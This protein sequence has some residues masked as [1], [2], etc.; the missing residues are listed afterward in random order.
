[1]GKISSIIMVLSILAVSSFSMP[2]SGI[3][4]GSPIGVSRSVDTESYIDINN[5]LVL[6]SNIG[7]IGL[8]R[9]NMGFPWKGGFYYPYSGECDDIVSGGFDK[10]VLYTSGLHL[11]GKVGGTIRTA[12]ATYYSS[13]YV[14]GPTDESGSPVTKYIK[15]VVI[16]LSGLIRANRIVNAKI[17]PY[18]STIG[19]NGKMRL[20]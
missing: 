18:I 8:D 15:F 5:L 11:A 2:P 10:T 1:M 6:I 12:I 13:E 19:L 3:S 20:W 4:K 16:V 9:E 7:Q 14:P 17:P